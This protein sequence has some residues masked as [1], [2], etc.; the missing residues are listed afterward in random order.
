MAA[1]ALQIRQQL[2]CAQ[3]VAGRRHIVS[4]LGVR[5]ETFCGSGAPTLVPGSFAFFG[6]YDIATD[7]PDVSTDF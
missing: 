6:F 7:L 1:S 3:V 2:S 5:A 4:G